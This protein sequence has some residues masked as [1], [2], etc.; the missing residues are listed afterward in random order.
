MMVRAGIGVPRHR[1]VASP[2]AIDAATS[3][4]LGSDEGEGLPRLLYSPAPGFHLF[5]YSGRPMW[6]ERE[7]AIN[8]QV[9]ETLR[10]SALFAPRRVLEAML[11]DPEVRDEWAKEVAGL[12]RRGAVF[13]ARRH[14]QGVPHR[15]GRL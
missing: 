5:W 6:I 8:L 10:I 3:E 12:A 1:L 7:I 9:I 13:R 14:L 15:R 11:E 4:A 2:E